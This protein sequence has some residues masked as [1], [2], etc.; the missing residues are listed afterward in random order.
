MEGPNEG[1]WDWEIASD[2]LF[3]SPKMNLLQGQNADAEVTTRAAWLS[4]IVIHPDDLPR[5]EAA[6]RDHLEGRTPHYDCQYR[7]CSESGEWGWLH[8][9]GR[10]LRDGEG[11]RSRFVGSAIDITAQKQA[12]ID[13]DQLEG[14]LRQSQK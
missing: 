13:K 2:R 1:H 6:T 4:R 3:L 14:Q 11:K 8:A 10:C 9:R 5:F 7:G 12:Q